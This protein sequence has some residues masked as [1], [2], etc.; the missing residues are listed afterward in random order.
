MLGLF[1]TAAPVCRLEDVDASDRPRFSRV[2]H[3]LLRRGVHLPPSPYESFLAF[4][5][6]AQSVGGALSTTGELTPGNSITRLP[7]RAAGK[8]ASTMAISSP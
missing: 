4:D 6:I 7:T 8:L 3:A 1:F 2:F 5:M